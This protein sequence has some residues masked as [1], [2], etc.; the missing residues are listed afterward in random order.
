MPVRGGQS[1]VG[2]DPQRSHRGNC[3]KR[4][5]HAWYTAYLSGMLVTVSA[6][7]VGLLEQNDRHFAQS[8]GF[9]RNDSSKAME[10]HRGHLFGLRSGPECR[11]WFDFVRS[12]SSR[13]FG[14]SYAGS[15]GRVD[16][17]R[18]HASKRGRPGQPHI[19]DNNKA[20]E[21]RIGET[22]VTCA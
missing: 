14:W 12:D 20:K 7:C 8:K 4:I 22:I 2:Q 17:H 10:S 16:N 11:L 18:H 6:N 21:D 1:K 3:K 9:R 15:V 19:C 13:P 5:L